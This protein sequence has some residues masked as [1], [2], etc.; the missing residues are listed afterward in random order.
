MWLQKRVW[1]INGSILGLEVIISKGE[2]S[3]KLAN[4]AWNPIV[5]NDLMQRLIASNVDTEE[6]ISWMIRGDETE[7]EKNKPIKITQRTEWA[8]PEGYENEF[9][10]SIKE[11]YV[12]IPDAINYISYLRSRI[13][14]HKV[15]KRIM[16]LSVFDVA[17]AQFL[18]R[19]LILESMNLWHKIF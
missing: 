6:Y 19:R 9:F 16:Q 17:N 1:I 3:S 12:F 2:K 4:G 10:I 13:A 5:L 14:S 15:G 8:D 7:I 11:G 18:A